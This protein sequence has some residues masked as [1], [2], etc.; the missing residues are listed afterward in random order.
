[1]KGPGLSTGRESSRRSETARPGDERVAWIALALTP[2][3][4]PRRLAALV[5]RFGSALAVLEA[6]A[7]EVGRAVGIRVDTGAGLSRARLVLDST[8]AAGQRL[9]IPS[10]P[11]YPKLLRSIPDPPPLLFVHGDP[12][13][14]DGEA[15]AMVGSRDHTGYGAAIAAELGA[16]AARAGL[17]VVSG[18]ARGLDAVAQGAA[19]DAGGTT[20]AVLGGGADVIYPMRNR[21]LH[22]RV[23]EHGLV[24][25]EH[26]PGERPH[27]AHF[28]RRNRIISGLAKALV[29]VEAAEGS[30]TLIT[31]QCALEQGREVLAVPGPITSATSRGTNGLIRD[32]ATP[33]LEP[34]DLLQV[35]GLTTGE[36]DGTGRT[37]GLAPVR[38]DLSPEEARVM[39]ALSLGERHV[40]L[41]ASEAGLPIGTV[42]GVLLGLELGGLVVQSGV[43]MYRRK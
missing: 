23:L 9:L 4:G 1:M 33:L 3:L 5:S 21:R 6:P 8:S 10:D 17:A 27:P 32:G 40:D 30:G 7:A 18:M 22:R 11:A 14:L 42:L 16:T 36:A 34:G 12:A 28:P 25:S 2:G 37:P 35:F 29:V 19:L 41:V 31:V 39:G 13:R 26:P 43:G 20:I 38:C 24:V 15:V